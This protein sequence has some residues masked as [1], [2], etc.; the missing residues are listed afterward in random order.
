MTVT[1]FVV[2]NDQTRQKRTICVKNIATD[3]VGGYDND[4][5]ALEAGK[6]FH[7][8]SACSRVD[9]RL[10]QNV[11]SEKRVPIQLANWELV[12]VGRN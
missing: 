2:I 1:I 7:L 10:V 4:S 6:R 9:I 3:Q 11:V 12:N 5:F 8:S